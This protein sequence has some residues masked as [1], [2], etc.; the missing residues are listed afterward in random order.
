MYRHPSIVVAVMMIAISLLVVD[1]CTT[2]GVNCTCNE[3]NVNGYSYWCASNN[4]CYSHS[5]TC[6]Y[7]CSGSC[8][9]TLGCALPVACSSAQDAACNAQGSACCLDSDAKAFCAPSGSTCCNYAN[10]T[11]TNGTTCDVPAQSCVTPPSNYSAECKKCLNFISEIENDG[12]DAVVTYCALLPPPFNAMCVYLIHAGLCQKIIQYLAGGLTPLTICEM[13]P[14]INL[15]ASGLTC[16]CGY[17]QPA[18][19]GNWCL[20]LDAACPAARNLNA[21]KSLR[22]LPSGS[23]PLL[24][25]RVKSRNI[26]VDGICDESNA[27]C[28]LTCA[29]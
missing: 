2:D 17:C 14:L 28:C 20:A 6:D 25:D 8:T 5:F 26:C 24:S 19:Y 13:I 18:M 4:E 9:N 12:C 27:G 15:C 10:V 1:A 29:P 3:C 11:C 22:Q 21:S 16:E 23:S 7:E